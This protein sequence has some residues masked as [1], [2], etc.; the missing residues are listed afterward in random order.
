MTLQKIKYVKA[1]QISAFA[2]H[3]GVKLT[4]PDIRALFNAISKD[5]GQGM[6]DSDLPL[7]EE[8]FKKAVQRERAY[9]RGKIDR[10]KI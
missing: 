6:E 8:T 7:E 4:A 2:E 1:G 10:D 3:F 9:W 5:S